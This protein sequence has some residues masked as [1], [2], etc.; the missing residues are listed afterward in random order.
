MPRGTIAPVQAEGLQERRQEEGIQLRHV[1][2]MGRGVEFTR[3]AQ[4]RTATRTHK[5]VPAECPGIGRGAFALVQRDQAQGQV[6]ETVNAMRG[7]EFLQGLG[8]RRA[9]L[10]P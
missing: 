10:L 1:A 2:L 7:K 8:T 9:A 4:C 5:W 3:L 6:V